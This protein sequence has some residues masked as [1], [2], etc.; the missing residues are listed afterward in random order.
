VTDGVENLAR[1]GRMVLWEGAKEIE[2][3]WAEAS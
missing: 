2:I 3:G 1:L